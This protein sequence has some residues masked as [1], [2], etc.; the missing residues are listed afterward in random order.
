MGGFFENSELQPKKEARERNKET[1]HKC[2]R[3]RIL[4]LA[5]WIKYIFLRE[6]S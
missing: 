4:W 6:V 1:F 3:C 2:S 5:S